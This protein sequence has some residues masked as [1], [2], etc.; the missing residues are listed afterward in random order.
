MEIIVFVILGLVSGFVGALLALTYK[1]GA[2]E[3][4]IDDIVRAQL[5]AQHDIKETKNFLNAVEQHI[6]AVNVAIKREHAATWEGINNL[7]NYADKIA[8]GIEPGTGTDVID[9]N[10]VAKDAEH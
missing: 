9:A 7:W 10:E 6:G 4:A 1:T 8:G 3:T 5:N 2:M